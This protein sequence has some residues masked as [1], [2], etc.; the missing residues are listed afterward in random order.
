MKERKSQTKEEIL[1]HLRKRLAEEGLPEP[2]F[3][4]DVAEEM[5]ESQN[6]VEA[7]ISTYNGCIK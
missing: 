5:V 3:M 2:F 4:E 6:S 7:I 1:A